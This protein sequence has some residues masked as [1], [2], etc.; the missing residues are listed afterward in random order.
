MADLGEA[1]VNIIPKAPG[2]QKELKSLLGDGAAGAGEPAGKAAGSSFM[3]GFKKLVAG[4][5]VGKVLKDAFSAGGDLQQSF[6]GLET[7]YGHAADQAKAFAASSALAGISANDFAEQAVSFGASLKQAFDGGEAE[8]IKA[9][10]TAIMDMADN[11]A[12]M[13]TSIESIQQAYQGFAKQNYTMLDNL[14]LGYGGTKTEMERLLAGA[15]KLTGVKYDISNL[16][17]VYDAI[18]VIQ[19]NLGITGVA[20]EEA[21]TT[22]TGSLGA[23]KA[24]W[25][26]TIA[27]LTSGEGDFSMAMSN[28][29]TAVGYFATNVLSMV[30][31]VVGQLPD[32]FAGIGAVIV[33]NAPQLMQSV[34]TIVTQMAQGFVSGFPQFITAF[35]LLQ[36]LLRKQFQPPRQ[37]S[38]RV[39][40]R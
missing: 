23:M 26:N 9:A 4:A 27:S 28:L 16:A 2:I 12:K 38:L 1:Y 15:Q 36:Q 3:A 39:A 6:G 8:A 29:S 14:K 7:I 13:G 25:L 11:S 31:N 17:D 40:S 18:H 10:N 22:L 35:Q 5:A 19:G 21:K 32:F 34:Q 20:A 37:S 24:S 33:S 30:G